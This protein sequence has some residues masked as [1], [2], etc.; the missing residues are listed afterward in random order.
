MSLLKSDPSVSANIFVDFEN[1]QP[2]AEEKD[3][4]AHVEEVLRKGPELLQTLRTYTGQGAA[5]S[6]AIS[7]PGKETE[8]EAWRA[9]LPQVAILKEFFEYSVVL[10]ET[11]PKILHSL[12]SGDPIKNLETK[13]AITKQFAELLHFVLL[14]DDLKMTTPAIQ[15]DFSYYRRTLSRM[16]M[17]DNASGMDDLVVRDELANKMSLFYAYP[18]PMLNSVTNAT[19]NFVASNE[20]I[21]SE[22]VT[23]C[24]ATMAAV[25]HNAVYNPEFSAKYSKPE[26]SIFCLRVMVGLII[27]FDHLH[28][29]GA[30]Y[31]G[32]PINIKSCI[33]LIQNNGNEHKDGLLN[34]LRYTTKHLNDDDTPKGIKQL[35][36]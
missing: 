15:N 23:S 9:V 17:S 35:L 28:P 10:E 5:I 21:P 29:S 33:K 32:S 6:K 26:T 13:Q 24:L 3:L 27:L 34:A 7:N 18:T 19:T 2:T 12:C 1:A 22:N 8:D 30:F 14:Y 16:K 31:K 25:C 20:S 11:L 4:Y 36:A